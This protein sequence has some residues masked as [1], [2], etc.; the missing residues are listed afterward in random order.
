MPMLVIRHMMNMDILF[1]KDNKFN[2]GHYLNRFADAIPERFKPDA[3]ACAKRFG[4]PL[5]L[6]EANP[7]VLDVLDQHQ[8]QYRIHRHLTRRDYQVFAQGLDDNKRATQTLFVKSRDCET[9]AFVV[10]CAQKNADLSPVA[11]QLAVR[12]LDVIPAIELKQKLN[13]PKEAMTPIGQR[14]FPTF[15][16]DDLLEYAAL[17][18]G[19]GVQKVHIELTP[20]D[21]QAV[22]QA[23]A[24]ELNHHWLSRKPRQSTVAYM[25]SFLTQGMLGYQSWILPI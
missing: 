25:V 7:V 10:T 8:A 4:L 6:R 15:I 13:Y 2:F 3:I 14:D 18:T 22:C 12:Q 1:L 9:Y 21:L 5:D 20:K 11:Q 23:T 24:V 16:D 17:T 19:G